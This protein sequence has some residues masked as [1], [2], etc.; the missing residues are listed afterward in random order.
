MLH[1]HE[2]G[3]SID[4]EFIWIQAAMRLLVITVNCF[5][6][7]RNRKAVQNAFHTIY[8]IIIADCIMQC[9]MQSHAHSVST[10]NNSVLMIRILIGWI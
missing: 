9:I 5:S 7:Y 8:K 1:V 3:L 6:A 10:E 2:Y 4:I